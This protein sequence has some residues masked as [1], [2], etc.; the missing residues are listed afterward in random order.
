MRSWGQ[1]LAAA[2]ASLLLMFLALPKILILGTD[3]LAGQQVQE[4]R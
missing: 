4:A 2:V 3:R 1:I